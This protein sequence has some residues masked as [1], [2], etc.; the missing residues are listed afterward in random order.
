DLLLGGILLHDMGKLRELSGTLS[1]EYTPEGRLIGHISIMHAQ[2]VQTSQ[3][4]GLADKEEVLLLRH[5]ILSHHGHYEFGSPVL[6]MTPEALA[7]SF[8][9]DADAKM[10]MVSKALEGLKEGE[11]SQRI[12]ALENRSLYKDKLEDK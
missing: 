9:D 7:L 11:F 2:L 12:F 10:N 5:M 1:T 4:L 8:I 3:K 6:P